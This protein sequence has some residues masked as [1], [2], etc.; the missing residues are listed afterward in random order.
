MPTCDTTKCGG[1]CCT[2]LVFQFTCRYSEDFKRF[3]GLRGIEVIEKSCVIP[4]SLGKDTIQTVSY[5]KIPL[6]CG[7]FNEET[8]KCMSYSNRPEWCRTYPIISSPFIDPKKC[9]FIGGG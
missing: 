9:G 1:A 7:N 8:K 4:D 2:H 5:L 3:L 6:V